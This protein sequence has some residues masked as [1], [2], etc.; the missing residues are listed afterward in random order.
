MRETSFIQGG[1]LNS[2]HE[3]TNFEGKKLLEINKYKILGTTINSILKNK[4]SKCPNYVKIDVDGIEH[5][6]L[7]KADNLLQNKDLKSILIEI[8]ENYKRQLNSVLKIMKKN[9][10]KLLSKEQSNLRNIPLKFKNTYNYIFVKNKLKKRILN[11]FKI[12]KIIIFIFFVISKISN[13]SFFK[14]YIDLLN[15]PIFK[16]HLIKE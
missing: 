5:L 7:S 13:F 2:Y 10:F 9:K 1:A 6:I 11:I 14:K 15:F 8:N 16:K 12:K 4:I 3:K